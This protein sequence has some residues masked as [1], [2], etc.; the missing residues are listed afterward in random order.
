MSGANQ[1]DV[2]PPIVRNPVYGAT[3]NT[4]GVGRCLYITN[5]SLASADAALAPANEG[6][7]MVL[8]NDSRY[9][10]CAAT[11]AVSYNGAWMTEAEVHEVGHSLGLL[12]DEYDYPNTTYSGSEPSQ[13]NITT[14]PVGQ[15]WSQWWGTNGIS[16]FQGAGYYLYGLFRP[17]IDC[18]MRSLGVPLCEVCQEQISRQINTVVHAI[19]SP[20]PATANVQVA[21]PTQQSFSFTDIVPPQNNP[22]IT[23]S[24]DGQPLA[25]QSAASYLFD[26]ATQTLGSHALVV[27]VQDQT[28]L[29]RSD[30]SHLLRDEF[31]WNITVVD[32]TTANLHVTAFTPAS[33]LVQ[34]GSEVDLTTTV[35]NDGPAAAGSFQVEHFLS[36]D[37]LWSTSDYYLGGYTVTGLAAGQDDVNTRRVRL[38]ALMGTQIN[39][40]FVKVD[41]LDAV[42]ESNEADNE[43]MT[44]LFGTSPSCTPVLEYRDDLLYPR[45]AN[46]VSIANGGQALP[47]VIARCAA[48]GTMYVIAWGFSGTS[49]G[50]PLGN[51]FT[52]PLNADA[53]TQLGL[54][55]LNSPVFQQFWGPLDAQGVGRA[56]LQ[57]PAG[58][59]LLPLSGHFAAVLLD[60]NGI[61]GVTNAIAIDLR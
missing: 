16:A 20:L 4:G 42:R 46:A 22:L 50:T 26:S 3:Y 57:W 12:A 19:E 58:L 51:G 5:T 41:R 61:A 36:V 14:S 53:G 43:R 31:T 6:R 54:A 10:G 60:G 44:T 34:P 52:A 1:P 9:G 27:T 56:T 23:W 49:P 30:P 59:N 28:T 33:V 47:T 35:H 40:L 18:L 21:V 55:L 29:V 17:R 7:V 11:F 48:P 2:T 45:D 15:K 13:A 38:P 8:V 32:P 24:L 39:R 25:G 37:S